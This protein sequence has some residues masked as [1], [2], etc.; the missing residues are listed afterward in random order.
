[1]LAAS[2]LVTWLQPRSAELFMNRVPLGAFLGSGPE[3]VERV[4]GFQQWLGAV[5]TV[6]HTYLPG[7]DWRNVEGPEEILWPWA[8]WKQNDPRRQLVINVPM[9]APNEAGLSRN[10]SSSLLRGGAA[11][12]FDVHYRTLADH[13]VLVGA[14]DAVI[15]LGWEMNGETYGGRCSPNPAA[16]KEYWRRIVAAMRGS[17]GARFRFDFAATRGRD[18]IPW[19]ECYPGDDVVDIVGSDSYDQPAGESFADYIN[20][21]LG[22]REQSDF[23]AAHGKPISFPEWGLFRN[24]DNPEYIQ[25]MH[26]WMAA[27]NVAYQTITDYCPHGV[28]GCGHANPRSAHRYRELFGGPDAPG[29][30]APTVPPPAAPPAGPASPPPSGPPPAAPPAPPAAPPATPTAPPAEPQAS[31]PPGTPPSGPGHA[32]PGQA[33]LE[34]AG[35]EQAG[36]GRADPPAAPRTAPGPVPGNGSPSSTP[37]SAPPRGPRPGPAPPT[38]RDVG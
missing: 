2:T 1:M 6:G 23:A 36:P 11:G 7:D 14:P 28:W 22:L 17:P 9:M 25:G 24:Y 18:E 26:D 16:W 3:G 34:H 31:A 19:T 5:V 33:G 15:V 8:R 4:D 20:E 32:G 38:A 12:A 37:T 29:G 30:P 10:V 27:H 21:P 13:L 35:A